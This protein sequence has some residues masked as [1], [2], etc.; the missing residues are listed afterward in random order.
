MRLTI[1]LYAGLERHLP[2][3]AKD[4][5]VIVSISNRASVNDILRLYNVPMDQAHLVLRNGVYI[6]PAQRD[7][8]GFFVD[9]DT[10]AIWPPVAG[11]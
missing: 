8:S 2:E 3:N 1:K 5:A 7:A 6:P 4:N 10:L 11:G 9:G